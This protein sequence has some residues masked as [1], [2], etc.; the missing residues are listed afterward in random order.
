METAKLDLVMISDWGVVKLEGGGVGDQRGVRGTA[1]VAFLSR[2]VGTESGS[3]GITLYASHIH[4]Q[5]CHNA[6]R[7]RAH[8]LRCARHVTLLLPLDA[9]PGFL[10]CPRHREK[11]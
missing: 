3:L 8:P 10:R 6:A 7:R 4:T 2:V 5:F 9:A 11:A 1:E